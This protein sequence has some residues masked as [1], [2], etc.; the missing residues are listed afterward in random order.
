MSSFEDDLLG[1]FQQEAN[2]I[3]SQLQEDL[4]SF[5]SSSER[6]ELLVRMRRAAHTLKGGARAAELP[7]AEMLSEALE[8]AL[9]RCSHETFGPAKQAV[10]D[11]VRQLLLQSLDADEIPPS[12]QVQQS[13]L[14]LEGLATMAE[15]DT[16]PASS[17]IEDVFEQEAKAQVEQIRLSLQSPLDGLQLA[18]SSA[19]DL[20][21][22]ARSI[23]DPVTEGLAERIKTLLRAVSQH[24]SQ[25]PAHWKE[26]VL[27]GLDSL[28]Q[29]LAGN[30]MAV[31]Q[32]LATIGRMTEAE[33]Q[34]NSLPLEREK[35]LGPEVLPS[36]P[37]V[38][39]PF[40]LQ[41]PSLPGALQVQ[42]SLE[43]SMDSEPT[44]VSFET[45]LRATFQAEADDKI[46]ELTDCLLALEQSSPENIHPESL[47]AVFR[48]FHSLKGAARS[49]GALGM[50][51]LCQSSESLLASIKKGKVELW[52]D[53]MDALHRAVNL[54]TAL[55]QAKTPPAAREIQDCSELLEGLADGS[56]A[57]LVSAPTSVSIEF[58]T[59]VGYEQETIRVPT[60]KL[61]KLAT[62][63]NELLSIK[64]AS[65]QRV[66]DTRQIGHQFKGW[67]LEWSRLQPD[68]AQ[69]QQS[70]NTRSLEKLERFLSLNAAFVKELRAQ[71]SNL[72]RAADSDRR[73]AVALVDNTQ[74]QAKKLLMYPFSTILNR[75]PKVARDLSRSLGKLVDFNLDGVQ[76]EIDRRIL[77]KLQ[78]PLLHLVRNAIDHGVES[79]ETRIKFNKPPRSRVSIYV[80]SRRNSQIQLIIRDDGAGVNVERV[81]QSALRAGLITTEH[82]AWRDDKEALQ[83]I[84]QSDVSTSGQVTAISGRGLGMAIVREQVTKLGGTIHVESQEGQGTTFTILLPV[85]LS[86]FRGI[87]VKAQGRV[88]V[89][90]TL[91]VARVLRIR[92]DRDIRNIDGQPNIF[93]D[94]KV[95]PLVH[96]AN[97]L[98]LGATES[99]PSNLLTLVLESEQRHLAVVVEEI[100]SEQEVLVRELRPPLSRIAALAGI[101]ILGTGEFAP[102]L[103]VNHLVCSLSSERQGAL[104]AVPQKRETDWNILLVDDS[105]TSKALLK[106]IMESAG[107]RVLT[108]SDGA[109][110]MAALRSGSW[111]LVVSD[112]EMPRVNGLQLTRWIRTESDTPNIPVILVSTLYSEDDRMRGLES[113][114]NAY[115][116]KGDRSQTALIDSIRFILRS[117]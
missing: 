27:E 107:Y 80:Q 116:V 53:G 100:V 69:L 98:G 109:E 97:Q 38:E 36:T 19:A 11:S 34:T 20:E 42:D 65:Q 33:T 90:P 86:T 72:T 103:N 21:G 8:N 44:E 24:P 18:I 82:P 113:G 52:R 22:A 14:A 13:L 96:L 79:P 83:L 35:D 93:L 85:T 40:Q 43:L 108:A 29:G 111:D 91:Q 56:V 62:Q 31:S 41:V 68:L 115:V 99:S 87:L 74:E 104:S 105:L 15:Q 30:P 39:P 76:V 17:A 89:F 101:S 94:G 23:D 60:R 26:I 55:N 49:V 75:L 81:R 112:V 102:I 12:S 70:D 28:S 7:E 1:L 95:V 10:V 50:E 6:Q 46:V 114:A 66:L 2:T 64:L 67:E 47:E 63:V 110:A 45:G 58:A 3:L 51:S 25:A 61:E 78:D 9:R 59:G 84:F 57:P 88:F 16:T 4:K 73:R 117:K 32:V 106:N 77:E 48:Q 37:A 71:V 92:S 5:E 54:L